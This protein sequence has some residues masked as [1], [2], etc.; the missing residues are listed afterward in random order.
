MRISWGRSPRDAVKVR[1]NPEVQDLGEDSV[2]PLW[3]G[4][5]TCR[6]RRSSQMRGRRVTS[7]EA[8]RAASP[9]TEIL[10]L[11]KATAS[12]LSGEVT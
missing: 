9:A 6:P 3:R 7:D 8:G 10:W 2:S 12:A 5:C 11:V 1:E 4:G